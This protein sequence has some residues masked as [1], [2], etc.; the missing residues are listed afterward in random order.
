MAKSGR[1]WAIRVQDL[2]TG[3]WFNWDLG[4]W[5][6]AGPPMVNPGGL[7]IAM[8]IIIEPVYPIESEY[9]TLTIK[10]D[11]GKVLASKSMW[12]SSELGQGGGLEWTGNMPDRNYNITL[13][14]TP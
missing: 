14:V 6:A 8:W 4:N 11:T 2:T 13:T 10:D 7:Y 5:D 1:I 12:V 3:K 9:M